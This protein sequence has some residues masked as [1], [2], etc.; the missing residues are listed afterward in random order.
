MV[1]NPAQPIEFSQAVGRS[2]GHMG[3]MH[4]HKCGK[5]TVNGMCDV[6][7]RTTNDV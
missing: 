7:V 5:L 2:N 4:I 1:E 3:M 6:G